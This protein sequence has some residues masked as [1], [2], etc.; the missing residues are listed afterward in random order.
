MTTGE[1]EYRMLQGDA[2]DLVHHDEPVAVGGD[3]VRLPN[4]PADGGPAAVAARGAGAGPAGTPG[5]DLSPAGPTAFAP[6]HGVCHT[7]TLSGGTM[8][9]RRGE[10]C[11]RSRK[12]AKVA[13]SSGQSETLAEQ[14]ATALRDEIYTGDLAPGAKINIDDAAE[15][16]RMSQ[17]P[18]REALRALAAV[19][20]V[21]ALPQRGYVVRAETLDDF[22]DTYNLRLVLEGL[23][24]KLSAPNL[25]LADLV[26]IRE[27]YDR[28]NES[29]RVKDWD[30]L[31]H[32]HRD[33]HFEI[34]R[35]CNSPWLLRMLDILWENSE[36]YQTPVRSTLAGWLA[37][38]SDILTAVTARDAARTE[39]AVLAHITRTK[40]V[41]ENVLIGRSIG[42]DRG[43]VVRE[44]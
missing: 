20:L 19:G 8:C 26:R 32:A 39:E 15:R 33:F 42:D 21:D 37:D 30:A 22:L 35:A 44:A 29:Y 6:P 12:E 38:H 18:V 9:L 28:L 36:R 13:R 11:L 1:T 17:V 34:Y 4:P 16:L 24:A 14:A 40:A 7:T 2:F 25:E 43:Q 27:A 5:R 31:R 23:A 10:G 41:I 3:P